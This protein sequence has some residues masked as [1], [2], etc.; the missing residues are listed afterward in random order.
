MKQFATICALNLCWIAAS[1]GSLYAQTSFINPNP[2]GSG[3][4]IT[5]P[6]SRIH[7]SIP[8]PMVA[9][10]RSPRPAGR[11]RSS[12][13][14]PTAVGIRSPHRARATTI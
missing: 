8:I 7:S 9:A 6:G 1:A 10:T 5:T 14:I 4:T 11:A 2:Y 13:L 12:T 3:Y